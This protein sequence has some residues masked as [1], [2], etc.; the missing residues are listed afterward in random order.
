M[1]KR[2]K[3][4][5][6]EQLRRIQNEYNKYWRIESYL[7]DFISKILQLTTKIQA[8]NF[9]FNERRPSIRRQIDSL[10]FL[11]ENNSFD[12]RNNFFSILKGKPCQIAC[13][14]GHKLLP[15]NFQLD[16]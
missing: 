1:K 8:V 14:F 9:Q 5:L 6:F 12:E 7:Q 16:S 4:I 3:Y 15:A 13:S 10:R 11:G 2:Y